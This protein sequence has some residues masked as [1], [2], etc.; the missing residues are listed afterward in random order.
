MLFFFKSLNKEALSKMDKN[1]N[2]TLKIVFV[3]TKKCMR[4]GFA[5]TPAICCR[6]THISSKL[7]RSITMKGHSL[8]P[9]LTLVYLEGHANIEKCV[10]NFFSFLLHFIFA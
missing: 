5:K 7:Y 10:H 6:K 8:V 2:L 9:S 4:K 3:I 1:T